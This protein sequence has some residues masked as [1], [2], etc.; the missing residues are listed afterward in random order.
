MLSF[1]GVG[2]CGMRCGGCRRT[3]CSG[4]WEGVVACGVNWAHCPGFLLVTGGAGMESGV[5]SLGLC[6]SEGVN[7]ESEKSNSLGLT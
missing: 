2:P 1:L 6:C 3:M 4:V 5:R 7:S